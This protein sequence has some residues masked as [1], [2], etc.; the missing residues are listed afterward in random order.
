MIFFSAFDPDSIKDFSLI[1]FNISLFVLINVKINFEAG[2]LFSEKRKSINYFKLL[3]VINRKY[4]YD[5]I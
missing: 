1:S 2:E 5:E 4:R 3:S